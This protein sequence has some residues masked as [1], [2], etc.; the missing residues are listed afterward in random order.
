MELKSTH[1]NFCLP[2][3]SRYHSEVQSEGVGSGTIHRA[4]AEHGLPIHVYTSLVPDGS[5]GTF[6]VVVARNE[7]T[8]RH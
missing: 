2:I 3:R 6:F 1:L 5:T 4:N 7:E 8:R